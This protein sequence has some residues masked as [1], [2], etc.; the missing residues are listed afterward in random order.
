MKRPVLPQNPALITLGI[1]VGLISGLLGAGGGF[2]IIPALIFYASLDIRTAVGT[3]LIIIAINSLIGFTGDLTH[4]HIN[5]TILL[6]ITALG[7]LGTFTGHWL[8]GKIPA[9]GIKRIFGGFILIIGLLILTKDLL[10]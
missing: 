9:S 5:W 2:I 10:F 1:A 6:P 4:H 7:I 3:S 8:S